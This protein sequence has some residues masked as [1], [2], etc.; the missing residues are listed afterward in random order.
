M[1]RLKFA[2]TSMAIQLP[3]DPLAESIGQMGDQNYLG[4]RLHMGVDT[5]NYPATI[6]IALAAQQANRPDL[7][8]TPKRVLAHTWERLSD[9]TPSIT[10]IFPFSP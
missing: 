2:F 9:E 3:T 6:I 1:S 7:I 10:L 5:L 8:R 4:A